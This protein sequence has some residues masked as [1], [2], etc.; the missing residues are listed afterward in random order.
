MN[1]LGLS[2]PAEA[3]L[4]ASVLLR[5]STTATQQRGPLS[6]APRL[7]PQ[8]ARCWLVYAVTF[9]AIAF[10]HSN[11]RKLVELKG[12][13]FRRPGWLYTA[14]PALAAGVLGLCRA[15]LLP[16]MG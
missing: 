2:R 14:V 6:F 12:R 16:K 1:V 5:L 3:A 11:E 7:L 10:V 13:M 8:I 15:A 4:S 9:F